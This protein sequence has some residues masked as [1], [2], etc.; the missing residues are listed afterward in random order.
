[1]CSSEKKFSF[2]PFDYGPGLGHKPLNHD[3]KQDISVP[4]LTSMI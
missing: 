3:M 4:L 1:M 2:I